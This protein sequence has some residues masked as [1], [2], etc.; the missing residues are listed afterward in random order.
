LVPGRRWMNHDR[1]ALRRSF[2]GVI[3]SDNNVDNGL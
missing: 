2:G 1:S 3:G